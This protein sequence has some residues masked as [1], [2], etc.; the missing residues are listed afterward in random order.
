MTCSSISILLIQNSVPSAPEQASDDRLPPWP[1][2]QLNIFGMVRFAAA[3]FSLVF[4]QV[5]GIGGA[6]VRDRGRGAVHGHLHGSQLRRH[7]SPDFLQ[8]NLR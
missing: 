3:D 6:I 8:Y 2:N 5:L 4:V 7:S 1:I